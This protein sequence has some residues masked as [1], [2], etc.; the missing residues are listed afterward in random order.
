MPEG[1]DLE[2]DTERI[3]KLEKVKMMLSGEEVE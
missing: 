2:M 3:I 1:L